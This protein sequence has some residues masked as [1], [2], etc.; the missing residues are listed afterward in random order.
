MKIIGFMGSP[1]K[2]SNTDILL[3]EVLNA[4]FELGAE[5]RIIYANDLKMKG[6]QSCFACKKT[7]ACV[8]NDDMKPLYDEITGA[9]AVVFASPV[10]MW[11]MTAQMKLVVD[12]LFAYL[13]PGLKSRLL[14][15]KKLGLIFTQGQPDAAIFA[16]YFKSVETLMQFLGFN[17][18]QDVFVAPGLHEPGEVKD[19]KALMDA[20]RSLGRNLAQ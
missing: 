3:Q 8:Q 7:G 11:G 19:N 4:A 10:Y 20:A 1:R 5:T 2:N 9:D 6:C 14:K 17:P 13:E 15:G 12:R 18:V 16:P